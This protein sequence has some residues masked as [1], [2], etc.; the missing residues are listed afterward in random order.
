MITAIIQART[1]STRLP[2]KVFSELAGKPLI[3][4]VV[5]RIRFSARIDNIVLATTVNPK[6]DV[7]ELWAVQNN[8]KVFRGSEDD[9]LSRYYHAADKYKSDIIVRITA[10]DP[11]KDPS[12]FDRVIEELFTKSLDFAYNNNPP[13]FPEG[14]DTEIFT[15]AALK[16]SFIEAKDPFEREHVTQY[17]YRHPELFKQNNITHSP[18]L[19]RMRWTIDT[20]TDFQMVS[21]V[22]RELYKP[23]EIFLMDDIVRLIQKHP[24]IEAI[25]SH[26]KRSAMYS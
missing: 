22:Y 14:L 9:V 15:F 1:G 16:R 2:N 19:S 11:F 4:H 5:E 13:T 18:D 17:L 12:I 6:D 8:V 24:E 3:A 25:N 26:V 10:D 20:Q 7:L 23:G 21:R